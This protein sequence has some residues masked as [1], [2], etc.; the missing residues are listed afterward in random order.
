MLYSCLDSSLEFSPSL[1]ISPAWLTSL[2]QEGG[3]QV[4][5]TSLCPLPV[6]PYLLHTTLCFM[7]TFYTQL[8]P[9]ETKTVTQVCVA[10]P[11]YTQMRPEQTAMAEPGPLFS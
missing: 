11:L 4:S 1:K 6:L 8:Y 2:Q 7:A 10:I 9:L 5:Q 3:G